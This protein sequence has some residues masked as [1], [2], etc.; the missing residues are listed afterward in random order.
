[1]R[2]LAPENDRA[3]LTLQ[4][5]EVRLEGL[6]RPLA[7]AIGIGHFALAFLVLLSSWARQS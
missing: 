1:L 7:W 4:A 5:L 3:G 6:W 2:A